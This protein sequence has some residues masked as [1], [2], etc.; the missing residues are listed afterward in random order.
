MVSIMRRLDTMESQ[1]IGY[2]FMRACRRGETETTMPI[3]GNVGEWI[4]G[5]LMT[6]VSLSLGQLN[7]F[8]RAKGCPRLNPLWVP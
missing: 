5:F 8:P 7:I 2:Q 6:R 1:T 3:S 4:S